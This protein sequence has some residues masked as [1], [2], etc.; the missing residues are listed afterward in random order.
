M[1]QAVSP[2]VPKE[3]AACQTDR[4]SATDKFKTRPS[5]CL[6]HKEKE[7]SAFCRTCDSLVC[8]SC[9][10]HGNHGNHKFCEI[11]DVVM[12]K[13]VQLQKEVSNRG[14]EM[15]ELIKNSI[16]VIEEEK[17]SLTTSCKTATEEVE[18]K[19]EILIKEIE[20]WSEE[21]KSAVG[22]YQ[23]G[24]FSCLNEKIQQSN[25]CLELFSEFQDDPTTI[26][27]LDGTKSIEILK[28]LHENSN[29]P[30]KLEEKPISFRPG[31]GFC[32][33]NLDS[34]FGSLKGMPCEMSESDNTENIIPQGNS[35]GVDTEEDSS[36]DTDSLYEDAESEI[37][38]RY[39]KSPIDKI[40]PVGVNS[41]F[42]VIGGKLYLVDFSK[43]IDVIEKEVAPLMTDV[44]HITPLTHRGIYVQQEQSNVIS[45]VT[46]T[47]KKYRF[48]DST[49]ET[50]LCVGLSNTGNIITFTKECTYTN[51]RDFYYSEYNVNGVNIKI[52]K[53]FSTS[54]SQPCSDIMKTTSALYRL[55]INPYKLSETG[56]VLDEL[57]N[58]SYSGVIGRNPAYQFCPRG[59]CQD[60]DSRL[61]ITDNWNHRVHLLTRDGQ[62]SKFLMTEED[63]LQHPIAVAMDTYRRL[64]IG[65]QDGTIHII[66][67]TP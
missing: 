10:I 51:M 14:K 62:F 42:V 59:I 48:M 7:V 26:D 9:I 38:Y 12:E 15:G 57:H 23:A 39:T 34:L 30:E 11:S 16:T 20:R 35:V 41:A 19:K 27:T 55:R 53:R 58:K 32:G 40:A 63:G 37:R 61:I 25:I 24:K 52:H 18:K 17:E 21:L 67:Y 6:N 43:H 8:M 54:F 22:D 29:P 60:K 66:S 2:V 13:K 65:Q 5:Y 56:Y 44:V 1:A 3:Q 36:S 46:V 31:T 45:R 50:L 49:P 28:V 4:Q 47:G 64:W 33:E